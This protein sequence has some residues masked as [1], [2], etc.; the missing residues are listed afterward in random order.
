MSTEATSHSLT[1]AFDDT[2]LLERIKALEPQIRAAADSIEAEGCLPDDLVEALRAT[3]LF[4]ASWPR[5]MGGLELDPMTQIEVLEELSRIDGS[6]GWAGTFAAIGGLLASTIDPVAALELF[7]NPDVVPA[8]QY[9]P[10]GNA[11]RVEGGYRVTGKWSFGS[12]CMHADVITAGCFVT[13]DGEVQMRDSGMPE[14]CS[15]MVPKTSV[16]ILRDSWNVSGMRGTGS[17]DYTMTDVFVP[18]AHVSDSSYSAYHDGPLYQFPA[19]FLFSHAP[20]PLGIARAAL[21]YLYELGETKRVQPS[22]RLF[23]EQGE[24]HE[25]LARSEAALR[26]ARA[27]V[28][29]VIEDIWDTAC[30]GEEIS[31]QQRALFR[32]C[33]VEVS[34]VARDVVLRI[35]DVIGSTAIRSNSPID[36][37]LR[38]INVVCAHIVVQQKMYRPVGKVLF[39]LEV[40]NDPFF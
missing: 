37:L 22:N 10:R 36:R 27:W 35:H 25:V 1:P 26:S 33:L 28:F 3:G 12:G 31:K 23:K 30:R 2:S 40:K 38:D 4:R 18:A 24:A 11:E 17:Y 16:N 32:L 13:V 21:D 5:S 14:V 15:V 19:L 9:S 34:R 20:I 29:E 39:G 8:G 7:P 6:V